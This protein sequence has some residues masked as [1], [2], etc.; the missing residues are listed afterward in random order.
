MPW[1]C[2][3]LLTREPTRACVAV[4][5][6]FVAA[7]LEAGV[8]PCTIGARSRNVPHL[9]AAGDD[10]E[11]G[12]EEETER[13]E[14]LL[15][16]V[17]DLDERVRGVLADMVKV[18]APP[19]RSPV[20]G[21][22]TR[23]GCALPVLVTLESSRSQSAGCTLQRTASATG[24]PSSTRREEARSRMGSDGLALRCAGG[25]SATV[26]SWPA[27]TSMRTAACAASAVR[28]LATVTRKE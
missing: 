10:A 27:L 20:P 19:R 6:A 25:K 7:L 24:A 18:Y 2:P 11:L 4:Q 23:F 26:G 28:A 16:L 1:P 8:E 5:L 9:V 3:R 22:T 21:S 17:L 12:G 15:R 13:A 14:A